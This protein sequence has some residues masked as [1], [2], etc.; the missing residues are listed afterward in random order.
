MTKKR[1][2]YLSWDESFI[3]IAHVMSQRSKDP[4]TLSGSV[5]VDEQ[6]VVVGLGYNGFPRGVSDDDLPWEREGDFLDTKYAY[7]VHAEENAVYN[8][9]KQVEGC[10][11]YC[12]MF[13]CNECAKTLI[14]SGIKEIIYDNDQYHDTEIWQASRKLFDMAGVKYRQY[15]PEY[16]LKLEKKNG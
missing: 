16:E 12:T 1:K 14:Q 8:A 11:I 15:I 7:V 2:D 3:Q 13:P 6:G 5:I 9:N 10:K 4:N